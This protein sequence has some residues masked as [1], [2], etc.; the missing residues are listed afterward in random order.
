MQKGYTETTSTFNGPDC[1]VAAPKA[2]VVELEP[3]KVYK[4]GDLITLRDIY[5][6]YDKSY[7]RPDA[8]LVLD[9]LVAIM[10]KYPS[11]EIDFGS[12]TDSR[13]SDVYNKNLS[14]RRTDAAKAYL[15]QKGIAANRV[16]ASGYG[17]DRLLNQCKNGVKCSDEEHQ[18]NRRTE[19]KVIKINEENVEVRKGN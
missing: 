8:A 1:N 6:D 3:E 4:K 7:I 13:G 14:Q 17:E 9:D 15:V 11:M 12:H 16:V 2:V 18:M 19:V 10:Q 5:Y